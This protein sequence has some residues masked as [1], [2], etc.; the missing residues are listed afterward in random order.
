MTHPSWTED[1]TVP[2][3]KK[4]VR[5]INKAKRNCHIAKSLFTLF[6]LFKEFKVSGN[7]DRLTSWSSLHG[8]DDENKL[9]EIKKNGIQ[10]LGT[11]VDITSSTWLYVTMTV[12][13]TGLIIALYLV[14]L[15]SL[16]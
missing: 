9:E 14:A 1:T 3:A 2:I 6:K 13:K 15:T 8:R 4:S 10:Q 16:V 12:A 5:G 11:R 7:D